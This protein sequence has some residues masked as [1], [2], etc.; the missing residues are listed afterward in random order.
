M[1][2]ATSYP[3]PYGDI[4]SVGTPYLDKLS[5]Q[6]YADQKQRELM[7]MK[8][9]QLF[10]EEYAKNLAQVR[11]ADVG[12]MIDAY[13]TYKQSRINLLKNPNPTPQD[14][15]DLLQKKA[16]IYRVINGSKQKAADEKMIGSL[17]A[18]DKTGRFQDNAYEILK[19]G[20]SLPYD[21]TM[22]VPDANGQPQQID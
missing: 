20:R 13:N 16:D 10:N 8:N 2:K 7:Q 1:A 21:S 14:Q 5:N 15:M 19:N 3:M 9:A 22:Q 11:P 18:N 6:I 12:K 4:Y 17:I